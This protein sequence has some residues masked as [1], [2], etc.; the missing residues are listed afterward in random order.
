MKHQLLFVDDSEMMRSFL[1][2]YFTQSYLVKTA[3]S[4]EE[5]WAWLDAGNF[6]SLI[7]LDLKLG[8][9]SGYELLTQLKYSAL[10]NDIPVII[11][12]SV[13][14]SKEKIKCLEAGA[15]DYLIKPFNPKEL[16][17]RILY[18]LRAVRV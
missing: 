17:I 3:E 11:L 1:A 4:A 16:E 13:D 14:E 10:F 9:S 8:H 15:A 18:H 5:T 2:H 7:V 6:P 12:S